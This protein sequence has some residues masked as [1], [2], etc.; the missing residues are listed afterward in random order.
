MFRC[1]RLGWRGLEQSWQAETDPAQVITKDGE[2]GQAREKGWCSA[3]CPQCVHSTMGP[4]W[5]EATCW[6]SYIKQQPRGWTE[7]VFQ[8]SFSW[9]LLKFC[10]LTC[11]FSENS[12]RQLQVFV[13]ATHQTR[14]ALLQCLRAKSSEELLSISQVKRRGIWGQG[15]PLNGIV[16][17][18]YL[19]YL[20]RFRTWTDGGWG[21]LMTVKKQCGI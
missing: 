21:F 13:T 4:W 15:C 19:S 17:K 14:G 16:D 18:S 5:R 10:A 8:L 7:D 9:R 1:S 2:E 3:A 12:C 20:F 6:S 11:S